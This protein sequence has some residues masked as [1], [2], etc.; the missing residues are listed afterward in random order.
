MIGEDS[1]PG[2]ERGP[3]VG[4][5]GAGDGG[6]GGGSP[7]RDGVGSPAS[8]DAWIRTVGPDEAD[9]RLRRLYQRVATDEGHVDAIL[10]AH[11]LRPRTL[12]AHLSLYK[13]ALHA[14][15]HALTRRER[16]LVGVVVSRENG[17]DYCVRH[18]R[19]GLARHVGDPGRAR[20]MVEAAADAAEGAGQRRDGGPEGPAEAVD[21]PADG[22]H[23]LLTGRERALCRYAVKLTRRPDAVTEADLERLREAGLDDAGILDAN[24]VVA[25]FAY[26]NRTVQGLGVSAGSEPLGLHPGE[27]PG[28]LEHR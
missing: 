4:S 14:R 20:A 2:G 1:G 7:A 16:E 5:A 23:G 19:A 25:Y 12:E 11:S 27:Q 8:H 24:Q 6:D 21:P 28:D 17:C 18:H 26:A 10:R 3:S 15:P 13:A 9:G 22:S